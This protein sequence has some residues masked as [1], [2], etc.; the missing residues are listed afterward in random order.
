MYTVTLHG[1][2]YSLFYYDQPIDVDTLCAIIAQRPDYKKGSDIRLISCYTGQE[3]DGVARYI[4]DKLKV[5]VLAPDKL[6][7]INKD[8]YGRYKVYSGSKI[9]VHDGNMVLFDYIK[10][11][12]KND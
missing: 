2:P 4:A 11:G 6:G 5:N 1:N 7:I 12:G 9:G 8:I 3:K 10:K